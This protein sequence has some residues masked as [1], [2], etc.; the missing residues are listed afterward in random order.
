MPDRFGPRG[1]V[2]VIIPVQNSNM[3]PEYELMRPAGI[4]H[5]MYRF[6][7][8]DHGKVPDAVLRVVPD[9][10]LCW[11]DVIIGGNSLEMR[12]WSDAQQ[13]EYRAAFEKRAKGVPVVLAT[14]ATVAALRAIG[15]RRIG[16]L[17]PMSSEYSKGAKNYYEAQGFEMPYDTSL[18]VE[19]SEDIIHMTAEDA[20]A[21]F[22]R[23]DTDDVDTLLH[24]GGA[25]GIVSHIEAIEA[26]FGKPLVSVNAAT[27]W[28]ALRRIG[29]TDPM[30]GFGRL[31]M[32]TDVA[33]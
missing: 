31:L 28:Y 23:I 10:L 24:I 33:E 22:E 6:D 26:R 18:M 1:V 4:S 30:P 29:V 11:P 8:S 17:S 21:A 16:L 9:T 25:L 2:A 3:Q 5:Q 12:D 14:D 15:A 27:Y 32:H 7:I 19:K 20:I 13:T